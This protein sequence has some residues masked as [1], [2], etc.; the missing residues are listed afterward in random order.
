MTGRLTALVAWCRRRWY[1]IVV[2]VLAAAWGSWQAE[3]AI[4]EAEL[5]RASRTR[6][7]NSATEAAGL[8][9]QVSAQNARIEVIARSIE[10]ATSQEARD[11]SNAALAIAIAQIQKDDACVALYLNGERPAA[12]TD[13]ANRMDALRDGQDPF[14]VVRPSPPPQ[15]TTG[16]EDH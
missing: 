7:E 10:A 12:C 13:V 5:R 9:R 14:R 15:P 4:D 1:V 6:I 2:A 16:E 11:R 8:A 3:G